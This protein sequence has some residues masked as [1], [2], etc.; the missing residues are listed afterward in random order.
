MIAA[1]LR[2][3]AGFAHTPEIPPTVSALKVTPP[4]TATRSMMPLNGPRAAV[5]ASLPFTAAT[6]ARRA[7]A[8]RE[9]SGLSGWTAS[10]A[11]LRVIAARL[12]WN[13]S[14]GQGPP[15]AA[16][17]LNLAT[18]SSCGTDT[19][20]RSPPGF[21]PQSTNLSPLTC[22]ISAAKSR[23]PLRCL[24]LII[25]HSAPGESPIHAI[26]CSGDGSPQC[27]APGGACGP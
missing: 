12:V 3:R 11:C 26:L 18:N 13:Q 23:P 25:S 15:A 2:G 22:V 16:H 7:V 5:P 19:G 10:Q 4:G 14:L 6:L 17:S 8:A 1:C 27:G 9:S 24:S 21:Q 20:D